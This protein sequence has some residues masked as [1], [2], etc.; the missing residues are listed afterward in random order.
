MENRAGLVG[1]QVR[2]TSYG[3]FKGL[4]G[5]IQMVDT[6]IDDLEAVFGFYLVKLVGVPTRE[7]IWLAYDEVEFIGVPYL[8]FLPQAPL[9]VQAGKAEEAAE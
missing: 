1:N 3:P 9:A 8:N 5:T 7:P 4:K 2:V 6:I